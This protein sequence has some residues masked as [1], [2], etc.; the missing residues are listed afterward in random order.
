MQRIID[1]GAHVGIIMDGN[2]RWATARGRPRL[3]GHE[4]GIEALRR[5]AEAAPG[6]GIGTLTLYAFSSDNWRRPEAEVAGLMAL[7]RLYLRRE[8]RRLA[9]SGTRLS[10]I[11]RRDRLP[12]GLARAIG[13]A[14]AA[15]RMGT[16]LHLRIAIDYSGR[17]AILAAAL[18]AA[19]DGPLTREGL[20]RRLADGAPAPDVDLLIRTSGEQR[21][22]DFLL[23]ESAYAEL[24]FTPRL[25]PDFGA[26]DLAEAMAAF[27]A[28]QRRFGGLPA[29]A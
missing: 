10:V 9:E 13:R 18:S 29:A 23:W 22:S 15:T 20:S 11:G 8:A 19:C 5:V 2:G 1:D 12:E 25:W 7:M 3:A 16:R 27:R 4:A 6:Q 14:E 26:D 21:L 17:D 28:R 24:H